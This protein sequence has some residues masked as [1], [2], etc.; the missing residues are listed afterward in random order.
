MQ[1]KPRF[2]AN[3][4]SIGLINPKSPT[5]VG[6]V[7]R[8]AGCFQADAIFYTGKRY[9]RAAKFNTDTHDIRKSIPLTCVENLAE[10]VDNNQKIVCVE[11]VEDA[12]ALPNFTHP[13]S[14]LYIFG[15][16]DGNIPQNL[17]NISDF[18]VYIPTIGCMNLAQTVNVVLYD[19]LVKSG[20]KFLG[21]D[22]I[23]QSRGTNNKLKIKP[24]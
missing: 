9:D 22:L 18:V 1:K 13:E 2:Q 14:A 20:T 5:N 12:I 3:Y 19:R 4:V 7:M 23:V 24:Q 17:I 16:E 6:A 15:S 11:L 8:S 10:L 21:N